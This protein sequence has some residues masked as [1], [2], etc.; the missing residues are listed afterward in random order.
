MKQH[1]SDRFHTFNVCN[2][3]LGIV[4]FAVAVSLAVSGGHGALL[5]PRPA[6]ALLSKLELAAP[7]Y[8]MLF[9][10]L[11]RLFRPLWFSAPA[12]VS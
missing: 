6:E 10:Y 4:A 11:D 12:R 5:L 8:V 1:R 7:L 9:W 2:M 3:A